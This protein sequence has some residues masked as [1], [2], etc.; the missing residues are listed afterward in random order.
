MD[1]RK[2]SRKAEAR[3]RAAEDSSEAVAIS[4]MTLWEIAYKNSRKQLELFIPCDQFLSELEADFVVLPVDRQVAMHAA[5]LSGP[6]PKDPMDRLIAA[7]ALANDLTLITA[8]GKIR[9]ANLCKVLW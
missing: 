5:G 4:C 3:L 2:L 8:D 6:F 9:K 1:P 7:T